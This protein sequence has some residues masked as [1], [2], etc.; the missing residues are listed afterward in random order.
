MPQAGLE[1]TTPAPERAK[2][3]DAPERAATVVAQF[4]TI[5]V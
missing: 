3:A 5:R 1:P 2:T 4:D